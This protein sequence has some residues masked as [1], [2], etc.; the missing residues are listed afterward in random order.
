[1]SDGVINVALLTEEHEEKLG[2]YHSASGSTISTPR[3]QVVDTGST[4]LAGRDLAEF[5]LR[6][7]TAIPMAWCSISPIMAGPAR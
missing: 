2:L 7:S 3:K 1:M 4:Y 5:V 6:A